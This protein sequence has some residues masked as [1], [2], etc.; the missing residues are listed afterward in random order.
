MKNLLIS[1]FRKLHRSDIIRVFSLTSVS[2]LVKM[3]AG[4]ISVKIVSVII[5]P[6]GVALVGQLSNASTIVLTLAT[7]GIS[8][9]V[10][11]YISEYRAD[12][13]KISEYIE[14]SI[15]ITFV[16]SLICS[17][18]LILGASFLSQYILLDRKYNFVFVIFG[19]TVFFY[20]ANTLLMS[21]INGFKYFKLYVIVSIIS[22]LFGLCLSL[23]L[24]IWFGLEG[25]LINVVTSQSLMFIV[26]IVICIR[27]KPNFLLKSLIS[28]KFD[29]RKALQ[30]ARF[31]L[32]TIISAF[33]V[34]VSQLLLRS[35]AI[36]KFGMNDAGCWEGMNR[37]S[38]MYLM[39]ITTSFSV[40]YMPRL[41]ELRDTKEIRQEV[42]KA[43]KLL[44]PCMLI[45]FSFIYFSRHIV[46]SI[47]FSSEFEKMAELFKWQLIGDLL[48]ISSWLIAFLMVAKAMTGL[49]CVSEI[50]SSAFYVFISIFLIEYLGFGINGV[51]IGYMIN[52]VLY[53]LLMYAFVWRKLSVITKNEKE[54]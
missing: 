37:L 3:F 8:N 48:K 38:N 43:Y 15:I 41:S 42:L 12:E 17:L 52:Y 34:P 44:F 6:A 7:A 26:S 46:I 23:V 27:I 24:V 32:M 47:L 50:L 4:F 21:I 9:G 53:L 14:T 36:K 10:T 20:S 18:C 45:G 35:Y 31:S 29:K 16:F 5:G 33:C 28:S 39:I 22:S 19:V 30:Y 54:K 1:I 51:V 25:A 49:F 13:K 40:Y 11:K 2:T